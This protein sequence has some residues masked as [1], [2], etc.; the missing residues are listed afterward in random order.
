MR[1]AALLLFFDNRFR[2]HA[3]TEQNRQYDRD[4]ERYL[5]TDIKS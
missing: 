3:G 1:A 5:V 4:N 2:D